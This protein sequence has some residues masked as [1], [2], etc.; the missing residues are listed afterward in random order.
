[1]PFHS[2]IRLGCFALALIPT[3]GMAQAPDRSDTSRAPAVVADTARL[4]V[5]RPTVVAFLVVPAG[6]VDTLPDLAVIADDWNYAMATLGDSL[7]ARGIG[8][9]LVTQP[10]LRISSAGTADV[11]LSL[12]EAP[13]A[14]YVF[15][16]PGEPACIRRGPA[17][18]DVILA[19]ASSFF[20]NGMS[21]ASRA[22]E[23]CGLSQ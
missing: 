17:E 13:A 15:A 12:E 23:A 22:R 8:F 21:P 6:A 16:R 7:E 11:F 19:A 20:S 5:T 3:A 4:V 18:L 10:R 1:M 2:L 14:G 9:A